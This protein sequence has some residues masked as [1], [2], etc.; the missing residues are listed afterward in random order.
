MHPRLAPLLGTPSLPGCASNSS[1]FHDDDAPPASRLR[2][3][4]RC[5]STWS[6]PLCWL[7]ERAADESHAGSSS[8]AADAGVVGAARSSAISS[9]VGACGG[10]DSQ[11]AHASGSAGDSLR[12]ASP[13][14]P[15]AS[16]SSKTGAG[17]SRVASSFLTSEGGD[18]I[19]RPQFSEEESA[20]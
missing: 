18:I 17:G 8:A 15:D 11:S 16:G 2:V 6:V 5:A 4:T 12:D 3:V 20:R 10:A 19:T 9:D 1:Q 7:S 13:S 14:S